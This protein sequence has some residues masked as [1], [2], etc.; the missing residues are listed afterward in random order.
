MV[1][2][3]RVMP[4]PTRLTLLPIIPSNQ[5][6]CNKK[7]CMLRAGHTTFSF[8]AG[9]LLPNISL[10][11]NSSTITISPSL[12]TIAQEFEIDMQNLSI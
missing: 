2:H 1:L 6:L 4:P 12:T 5:N 8:W 10:P 3:T 9:Y 11:V 7:S